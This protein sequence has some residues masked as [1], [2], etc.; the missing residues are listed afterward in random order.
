MGREFSRRSN[1][2][3]VSLSR[4]VGMLFLSCLEEHLQLA[5]KKAGQ[6]KMQ[7][8][9]SSLIYGKYFYEAYH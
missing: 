2:Q 4:Q 3:R 8:I 5:K 6:E 1:I 7:Q 9:F